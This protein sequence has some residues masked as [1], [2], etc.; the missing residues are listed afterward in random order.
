MT[1]TELS[2]QLEIYQKQGANLLMPSTQIQGLSEFHAPVIETVTLSAKPDD[3]DVYPHNDED[4]P[5]KQKFRLTKQ[6]LMKLSVCAGIIWSTEHT[7]RVDDGHDRNY[8]CYQ[9]VG[10]LKKADGNPIFFKAQYD[11][12]FE[13]IEEELRALYIQKT[14][15]KWMKDK[16]E[17]EKGDYVTYCV[18][19]DMLQKRKHKLKLAESGAMSRVVREILG[20]KNAY[21]VAELAKPF[22][23]A[24]IVFRPDYND[25]DVKEKMLQAHIQA[26]TGIYGPAIANNAQKETTPIDITPI[27][28]DPELSDNASDEPPETVADEELTPEEKQILDFENADNLSQNA[29]LTNLAFQVKYNLGDYMTRAKAKD[30]NEFPKER[31]LNLFKHLLSL[32]RPAQTQE[33][34]D[35]V[36][37]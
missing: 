7:R 22:V 10:G 21:T 5:K 6:A 14:K 9:A 27:S 34:V 8:V 20:L 12:D 29:A 16:S 24:R 3:G 31:R 18:Q 26:M 11:M 33:L 2:K 1:E 32:Q 13:V 25:K 35:D 23:M 30:L 19:R 4:D 37:F 36:P 17:K 15:G 28:D